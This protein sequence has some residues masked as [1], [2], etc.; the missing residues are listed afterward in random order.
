MENIY[1]AR[2][3]EDSTYTISRVMVNSKVMGANGE[4]VLFVHKS[5]EHMP[6]ALGLVI[7]QPGSKSSFLAGNSYFFLD[8]KSAK[9]WVDETLEMTTF[10]KIDIDSPIY[11]VDKDFNIA[12]HTVSQI[13]KQRQKDGGRDVLS[14]AMDDFPHVF[15]IS[16]NDLNEP[17][18]IETVNHNTYVFFADLKYA[19]AY[20]T[21][22]VKRRMAKA[23]EEYLAKIADY[24]DKL[25]KAENI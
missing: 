23:K 21:G 10:N 25:N 15:L 24:T 3:N 2:V 18:I 6:N 11:V 5:F 14:F 17:S 20:V 22:A 1:L 12:K 16:G 4:T 8:Y 7:F 9:A 13:S 19:K